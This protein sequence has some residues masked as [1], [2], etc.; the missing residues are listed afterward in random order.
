MN[1]PTTWQE[2]A[3]F[4][5]AEAEAYGALFQLYEEQQRRLFQRDAPGVLAKATEI[6]QGVRAAAR[7]RQDREAAVAALASEYGVE[8]GRPVTELIQ[9]IEPAAGGQI[10]ALIDSINAL[11]ARV[12]RISRNN[13]LFLSRTVEHHQALLRAMRPSA[14]SRT[15]GATG[16]VAT[17]QADPRRSLT[18]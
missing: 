16:R 3:Q 15:Y 12:R 4:L 6:E 2:I 18:A 9:R 11:I 14:C 10:T 8:P 13:L 17:A 7:Q 5:R 1:R